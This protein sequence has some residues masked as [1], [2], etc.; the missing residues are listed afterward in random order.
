MSCQK[1]EEMQ[2]KKMVAYVR[3]GNS[4]VGIMGCDD[5]VRFAIAAIIE[6]QDRGDKPEPNSRPIVRLKE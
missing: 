1:C 5:H 3:I 2:E 6:K 4:N